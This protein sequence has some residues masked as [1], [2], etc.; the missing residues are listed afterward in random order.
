[1]AIQKDEISSVA[2]IKAEKISSFPLFEHFIYGCCRTR[3]AYVLS[4]I[5]LL[6]NPFLS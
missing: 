1:M 3:S 4:A 2:T 6:Q 5:R